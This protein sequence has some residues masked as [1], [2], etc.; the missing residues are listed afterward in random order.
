MK[1]VPLRALRYKGKAKNT[2]AKRRIR[3][4]RVRKKVFGTPERPR[5]C[6]FRSLNHV[7]AQIIDDSRGHTLVAASDTD[8]EIREACR[9]KR[10]RDAAVLVGAL[11]AKRA[12]DAGVGTVVFDRGGYSYHGRVAAL[13]DAA[14]KEGLVF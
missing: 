14:R 10:K 2:W 6:V 7:N 3:H 8:A 4:I 9:G 11:V 12:R 1:V 13:A 5:L